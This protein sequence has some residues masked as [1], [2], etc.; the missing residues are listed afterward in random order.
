MARTH[1]L[2]LTLVLTGIALAPALARALDTTP[3]WATN[4]GPRGTGVAVDTRFQVQWSERMDWP[5]VEASF[6]YSDGLVVRTAGTWS[7]SDT[8][9]AS[10][11]APAVLLLPGT[12]YTVRFAS[13]ARDAAGNPLDQN[14][15]GVGGEP[16]DV[17]PPSMPDC[18]V[19]SFA[20]AAPPPDT[21]PPRVLSVSPAGGSVVPTDAPIEAR[22]SES[23]DAASV[24]TAFGY[25]DG[26]T[27]YRV[28]DGTASWIATNTTDDTLR[29]VPRLELAPGGRVTVYLDGAVARD[30]AGNLLDGDGDGT[31]GDGYSWT[32][33]IAGDARPPTVVMTSPVEGA[34]VVSVSASIRV[35]F[36]KAM[37]RAGTEAAFSLRGGSDP[38]LNASD[39]I[40][41]WSGTRFPDDTLV[42]NPRPN[43]RVATAYAFRIVAD[44]ADRE[45]LHFDGN[46]NGTSEGSPA[47][48]FE[49]RFT[50]EA[51]DLTPPGVTDRT[52]AA[53]ATD[54]IPATAI[55][56]TFSEPMNRTSVGYAFSYTDGGSTF[57]V[58]DGTVAWE[59]ASG[60]FS[61]QP[62]RALDF[63]TRYTVTLAAGVPTDSAGNPLNGGAE[64]TWSFTVAS[65]ADT[66]RPSIVWT[67]PFP[68]QANVSRTARISIVFSEAMDKANVQAS[69]RITGSVALTDFRWPN[70]ATVDF[71]TASPMAYRTA[72]VVFVL[73]GATDLAGNGL[74][75]PLEIPFTTEAWRGR[76]HGRVVDEGLS[77]VD[78]ARV[79]L[80]GFSVLTDPNGT[81][82]F[83]GVEEGAYTITVSREGFETR[84]ESRQ[85]E[86]E[87]G[88]LGTIV[89]VRPSAVSSPV[90]WAA[91]GALVFAAVLV[92]AVLLRRRRARP[93]EHYET[94]KPARVVVVEPAAR[95]PRDRP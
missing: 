77:P 7:H 22:F 11:F 14:R 78:G 86:P 58:A 95:P 65:Q 15:N 74:A 76:V 26:F 85:V 70:D 50:T 29:F 1:A 40:V 21:T 23:M 90:A 9:N 93:T 81:F 46:G 5:S 89:L 39:G 75:Q 30:P 3:P 84:T 91:L 71:A 44:A 25:S 63:G 17:G 19:W 64:E 2:L 28:S 73:T 16:C 45:G 67:S 4:W 61:F 41:A 51:Q 20:T 59:T 62:T 54:V 38:P 32:F 42:F 13:T 56:V 35:V 34:G 31:G 87:Q 10:S 36:S 49:L 94:W 66:V 47:D 69:I 55:A 12:T 68:D 24:E 92:L 60:A 52:P 83:E 72:Y 18:L 43:L 6:V 79:Q 37:A 48:D 82:A 80:N 27:F 88:D 57:S 33:F 8:T 53:S